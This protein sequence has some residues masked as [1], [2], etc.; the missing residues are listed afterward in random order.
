MMDAVLSTYYHSSGIKY[1][2]LDCDEPCDYSGRIA[3]GNRLMWRNGTLP[4]ILVGA[5]YPAA[6]NRQVSRLLSLVLRTALTS[7]GP[8]LGVPYCATGEPLE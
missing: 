5:Q 7:V 1:W 8:S 6:F 3:A 4:D 2:W